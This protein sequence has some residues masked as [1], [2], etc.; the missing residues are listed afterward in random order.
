MTSYRVPQAPSHGSPALYLL[1]GALVCAALLSIGMRGLSTLPVSVRGEERL[2]ALGSS[3][4]DALDQGLVTPRAGDI[5]DA[6]GTVLAAGRGEAGCVLVN[7]EIA[8]P[9]RL[10]RSGDILAER[11]GADVTESILTTRQPIPIPVR[12]EGE[13]PLVAMA[14]PGAV[15]VEQKVIGEVSQVVVESHVITQAVPMVLRRYAPELGE[16]VVALTF[17][18]GPWPES[19]AQIL[20]ILEREGVVGNFFML[21]TQVRRNPK[22]ARRV[23][24]GGHL[25]GNHSQTHIYMRAAS[26]STARS[27]IERAQDQIERTVGQR[28]GWYRPAG[29]ILSPAVRTQASKSGVRIILWSVDPQDYRCDDAVVLARRVIGATKPGSVILLHDG[30][31]DRTVTINALTTIIR[32]LKARGYTFATLDQMY[33]P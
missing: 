6:T 17:D 12:Y 22:L 2:V 7:G 5:V 26:A 20:E 14:S 33:P 18:D 15:G 9:D 30:G 27:E 21:G 28:P 4:Q 16:K 25:I 23:A 24:E 10:L 32:K 31:G 1:A 3:V 19:T 11:V 8:L 13:G 29:G